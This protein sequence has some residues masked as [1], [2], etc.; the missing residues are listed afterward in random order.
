MALGNGKSIPVTCS[1]CA[2][3]VDNGQALGDHVAQTGHMK[4]RWCAEC[5]R[6]FDTKNSRQQHRRNSPKHRNRESDKTPTS[7]SHKPAKPVAAKKSGIVPIT[8]NEA[9]INTA[10]VLTTKAASRK[11]PASNKGPAS[12][13]MAP[14][15]SAST[16]QTALFGKSTARGASTDHR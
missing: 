4:S 9:D 14:T 1:Q 6:L 11:K 3:L 15:A 10:P 16:N 2:M 13:C 7:T 12:T 5:N 8:S